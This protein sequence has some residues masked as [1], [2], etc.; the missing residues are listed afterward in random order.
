MLV[1]GIIVSAVADEFVLG[2]A[3]GH[4]DARTMVAVLGGPAL[5]LLGDWLFKWAIVGRPPVSPL[6]AIGVLGGLAIAGP[7]VTPVVLMVASVAVLVGIAMW[8]ARAR[9]L[10]PPAVE[11]V[12]D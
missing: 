7:H 11:L 10:C 12:A 9:R 8:E 4:A 3:G 2:H 5:F 1:A 6:L